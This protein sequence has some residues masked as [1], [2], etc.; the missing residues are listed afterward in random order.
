MQ[1]SVN[2][3]YRYAL[4]IEIIDLNQDM[5][6]LNS[7]F[8]SDIWKWLAIQRKWSALGTKIYI[9]VIQFKGMNALIFIEN[10]AR[11]KMDL[12][13]QNPLSV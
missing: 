3:F 6:R 8:S 1:F 4:K 13:G 5:P 7:I 2:Y 12:V 11:L 9:I 10:T